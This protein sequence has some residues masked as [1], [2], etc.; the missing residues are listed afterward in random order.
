[1]ISGW[2]RPSITPAAS[3]S[4]LVSTITSDTLYG[5]PLTGFPNTG[6]YRRQS[7]PWLATRFAYFQPLI[8]ATCGPHATQVLQSYFF[9]S[10]DLP[11]LKVLPSPKLRSAEGSRDAESFVTF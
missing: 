5:S 2:R 8:N 10:L 9:P 4:C 3:P 11:A 1:M 7:S 6:L